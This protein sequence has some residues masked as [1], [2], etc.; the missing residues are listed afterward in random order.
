MT[1]I[2]PTPADET[3]DLDAAATRLDR[4]VAALAELSPESRAVADEF[5]LAADALA[6]DALTTIVRTLRADPRG[7]ELLFELVDDPAVRMLLGMHG[8]IRMPDPAGIAAP[9]ERRPAFVSLEA[10]LRGPRA[11]PIGAC[12]VGAHAC[13]PEG[14]GCGAH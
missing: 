2:A 14:C 5:A 13:G 8:I 10:M 4:A 7:K 3:V 12:G 1:T 11:V 9:V 6:K